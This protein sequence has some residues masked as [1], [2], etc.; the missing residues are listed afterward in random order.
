MQLREMFERPCAR[1]AGMPRYLVVLVLAVIVPLALASP[2]LAI[3]KEEL[4]Q[5]YAPFTAC[6]VATAA[7]CVVATTTGGEFVLDHK[8]VAIDKTITL[9]GG[10]ATT[11]VAPEALIAP[12]S[13]EALSKTSLT[14]PGGLVGIPGLEVVGGEVTATAE[15]VG[16]PSSIVINKLAYASDK[17]DA[18]TLP[19][20]IKLS[21]E[22]LGEECFIGSDA[23]PIVLHLT[24]GTTSPP[25]PGQPITGS[26]GAISTQDK[27]LI[28]DFKGTSLVDND[29]AVPAASGC[30]GSLSF[31]I[32]PI[33]NADIGLPAAA[34][35][36][37][38]I[39]DGT[40]AEAPAASVKKY[41]PKP[42]KT[43][44]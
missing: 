30:G 5:D 38:A 25:S 8:A 7:D 26:K 35:S 29:F 9:Q 28:T 22:I 2:A 33:L 6:P 18:V 11:G 20:K 39:M 21:N 44:K 14:V 24:T 32:D 1:I 4:T 23:E 37:T 10:L 13:G 42:K 27:G 17:P 12:T 16:P 40:L 15:L 3:T 31:L 43:K 41:I 19:L 36:N 34:G